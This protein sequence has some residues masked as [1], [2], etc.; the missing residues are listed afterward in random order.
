MNS[1]LQQ[2]LALIQ[3]LTNSIKLIELGIGEYQ[4]LGSSNDFYY[5]PFQLISSGFERLMKCYICIGYLNENNV[6]PEKLI[7]KLGHDL[8]KLKTYILDNYYS[9]GNRLVLKEDFEYLSNDKE[10]EKIISLLSEFGK[11][12]RYHNMDII[13][14]STKPSIDVKSEWQD[15]ETKIL[16]GNDSL[17]KRFNENLFDNEVIYSIQRVIII[18]L[19]RFTRAITR[20]F[21]LGNLG[22]KAMEMSI[23]VNSF[24]FLDDKD[25]GNKDYRKKTTQY[26]NNTQK[27]YKRT[28]LDEIER[29]TNPSYVSRSIS[30]E[31][32]KGDWPF[33]NDEVIIECREQHWCIITI[34]GY[35]YALMD[36]A[37]RRYK[38]P[39]VFDSGRAILGK[40]IGPFIRMALELGKKNG[41]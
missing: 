26:S 28:T 20:Q 40:S 38:F 23:I 6:Y 8:I 30:K 17:Q 32:Y 27:P 9:I 5:L 1:R 37:R 34:E 18:H 12:A 33:Y 2:D 31:E 4:N 14:N 39:D 29:L 35:D 25:L 15:I 13:T 7:K 21:T 24:I 19:E 11:F 22:Q 3:E 16:L 10:L 36:S 41:S